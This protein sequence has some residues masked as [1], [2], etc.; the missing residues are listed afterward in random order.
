VLWNY[1]TLNLLL[2]HFSPS[3]VAELSS[4]ELKPDASLHEPALAGQQL[5][6]EL[7]KE[8]ASENL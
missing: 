4:F 2:H 7:R 8:L 3:R 5:L 6:D 1:P